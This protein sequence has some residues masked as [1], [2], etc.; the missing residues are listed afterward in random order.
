MLFNW[1]ARYTDEVVTTRVNLCKAPD[2]AGT[3]TTYWTTSGAT[4]TRTQFFGN[5][6]YGVYSLAR[7]VTSTA[8]ALVVWDPT[9]ATL[10]V[11]A[12]T[13][14]T[15]SA[16]VFSS[17]SRTARVNLEWRDAGGSVISTSN[18]STV[19][20][21]SVAG[22]YVRPSVTATAPANSVTVRIQ[23]EITNAV[24][25]DTHYWSAVLLEAAGSVGNYFDGT[26]FEAE[27][28]PKYVTK[29]AWTG[30][31]FA[32]TSTESIYT[33]YTITNIQQVQFNKGR[34]RQVDD[35]AIDRG[36][37]FIG[38]IPAWS[39]TPKVGN[40]ILFCFDYPGV[41]VDVTEY[42]SFWGRISDVRTNYGLVTNEDTV[43]ISVDGIQAEWG[44]AQLNSVS[45]AQDTTTN[46]VSQISQFAG[47]TL[48][49]FSGN[50]TGSALAW[51][52]NAFDALSLVTR[53][54]EARMFAELST[55]SSERNN[56]ILWWYGRGSLANFTT[57]YL[58]DGTTS[59]PVGFTALR[60]DALVFRSAAEEFYNTVTVDSDSGSVTNQT[61]STGASPQLAL[62]RDTNDV[63]E[64]QALNH[65]QY[66]LNQYSQQASTIRQ[67]SFTDQ[68]I[69]GLNYQAISAM[70]S[71]N[72][73]AFIG[74]RGTTYT[75]IVEG[76]GVSA[77]PGETRITLF[78]SPADNN[79]YLILDDADFG[80]LDSNK[81]S[82]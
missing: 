16:Y 38:P 34:Q 58:N 48:G 25:G 71:I 10:P 54:E 73:K 35:Y 28:P 63:S 3:P 46:Q 43:E 11:T 47:L 39:P 1:K 66:L 7:S 81:L 76:V 79:N 57:I 68:Q 13:Q 41:L 15:L 29:V 2:F 69:A 60:Y 24:N 80:K 53:T 23:L 65:A 64:T 18:G 62:T 32:S 78:L 21:S 67:I 30:V 5:A 77:V 4:G 40:R 9:T 51:T 31:A 17:T 12:G 27:T 74:F 44:R 70:G 82:F 19:A 56:P 52:G 37:L 59:V 75:A 20:T 49:A 36:S 55:G 22:T 72:S 42:Q 45:I 26:R 33:W 8:A 14:Y 61:A 6:K 50:S